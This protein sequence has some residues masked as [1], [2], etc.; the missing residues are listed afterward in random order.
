M[1]Y[2][3]PLHTGRHPFQIYI[4][5]LCILSGAL[6]LLNR[7]EPSAI[8]QL[9]PQ[10]M[11]VVW[12]VMLTFGAALAL[13][14]SYWPGGKAGAAN[15]LTVERIGLSIV[16]AAA[17]VYGFAIIVV[18]SLP[19]MVAAAITLGFGL[20]CLRRARDIGRIIRTAIRTVKEQ[21]S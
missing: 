7:Q 15:S 20:S 18:A 9:L 16:G 10:W 4:L 17:I 14:G 13:F 12:A 21:Q 5:S 6:L 19:G 11:R 8:Q 3:D 1:S 2:I